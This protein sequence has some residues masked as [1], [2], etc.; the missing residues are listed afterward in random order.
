VIGGDYFRNRVAGMIVAVSRTSLALS[1]QVDGSPSLLDCPQDFI[2]G[3]SLGWW[4]DN[5]NTHHLVTNHPEHDPDIQHIPFFAIT[6]AY[7]SNLFSTYYNHVKTFDG[8]SR[9]MVKHQHRT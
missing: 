3:L 2:G 1:V 4:T 7:F 9:F 8:F 5:H 6:T